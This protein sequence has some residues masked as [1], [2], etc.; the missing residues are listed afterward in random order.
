MLA[1]ILAKAP[2]RDP[3]TLAMTMQT[4]LQDAANFEYTPNGTGPCDVA[5]AVECFA[6]YERGY[7][8]HYASTMAILLRAAN[9]DNPIPTRLVQGFLPGTRDAAGIVETVEAQAAH[10]W[11]EVYFPGYGWIPFDPTGGGIGR[12]TVIPA[13]PQVEPA[14]PTPVGSRVPEQPDP[15]RRGEL[16]R[17]GGE[18]VPSPASQPVDRTVL[19]VLAV[20]LAA[21]V[22]GIAVATWM[23]GPRKEV[24]PDAAWATMLRAASRFGFGPRPTQTVYE[25]TGSLADLV[26]VAREDLQTVADAKV[27]TQYARVHLDEVRLEAVRDSTRRLRISLLRLAFR[28]SRR[29][30]RSP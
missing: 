4:Y 24:S 11:V 1:A 13:G 17:P 12:E 22:I 15:S 14:A 26:P 9:P 21:I 2:D 29:R 8:L 23:R 16:D 6:R 28:R 27:E 19:I 7:C 18:V 30:R 25:Y 20:L 10:A 3:Y 5:S